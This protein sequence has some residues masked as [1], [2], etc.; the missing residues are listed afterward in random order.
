MLY[1]FAS[2]D[3][4]INTLEAHPKC[5][6]FIYDNNIFYNKF[7][8]QSGSYSNNIKHIPPGY[9]SLYEMNIDRPANGLIYP[10]ITKDGT[11]GTFKSVS[12]DDYNSQFQYGDTIT[13][14]YPM[15]ASIS[16]E[17]F[18]AF[19]E[20]PHIR[21]LQNVFN[22]YKKYSMHYAYSSSYGNKAEQ[23]ITLVSIPSIFYGSEIEKGSVHLKFFYTGSLIA[24]LHD[25]NKN[26]ELI[27]VT[28]SAGIDTVA[29]VVLYGEGFVSLTGSRNL[30]TNAHDYAYG[31]TSGS[32]PI[33]PNWQWWGSTLFTNVPEASY[34]LE[35]R[36]IQ[37][38][39]VVTMFCRAPHSEL[40]YSNNPTY[41]EYGQEGLQPNTGSQ[42]YIEQQKNIKNTVSSSY[43]DPTGS[44]QKQTFISK[45]LLYD[46]KK[47]VIG[48]VNIAT[49]VRKTEDRD[50][51]FKL[52]YDI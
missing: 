17:H 35:F 6:F 45:I 43:A 34:L 38:T 39:N 5:E 12:T 40:N 1:K 48:A 37:Q 32:N 7:P 24:E 10:F 51:T 16:L 13:G 11:Q 19:E 41:I 29:G 2:S 22:D 8:L 52:T 42:Y 46:D 27:Q 21:A 44:F 28:G 18:S 9:I 25:K 20:R 30:D 15:S 4:L 49:P 26:G 36:G 3:I 31:A 50:I 33:R 23:P 47:N 14:S